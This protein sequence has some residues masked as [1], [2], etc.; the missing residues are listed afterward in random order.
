V[1]LLWFLG[2]WVGLLV[3]LGIVAWDR[4]RRPTATDLLR[5]AL[6]L[7]CLVP[8]AVLARGLPRPSTVT[9][10]FAGNNLVAH[11]LAGAALALLVLGIL[12]DVPPA[13]PPPRGGPGQA[14][15]PPGQQTGDET[16]R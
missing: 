3:G 4:L 11:Y 6:V 10:L 8:V 5:A 9:P 1:A 15:P 13:I 16:G 14:A 7:F 2:G 12:R